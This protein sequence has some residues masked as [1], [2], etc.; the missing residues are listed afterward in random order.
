[1]ILIIADQV[2]RITILVQVRWDALAYPLKVGRLPCQVHSRSAR[3]TIN[4]S[5]YFELP[6]CSILIN[7]SSPRS[8]TCSTITL[9]S[10]EDIACEPVV[11]YFFSRYRLLLNFLSFFI[12]R[13]NVGATSPATASR[14][15][16]CRVRGK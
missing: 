14:P 15:S 4:M 7:P 9:S 5:S 12:V 8:P 1:M 6:S 3:P 16:R 10:D 13:M 11:F 2:S